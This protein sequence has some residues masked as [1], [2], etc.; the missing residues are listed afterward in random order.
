MHGFFFVDANT[1]SG[2]RGRWKRI[3]SFCGSWYNFF[4]RPLV[5]GRRMKSIRAREAPVTLVPRHGRLACPGQQWWRAPSNSNEPP[6]HLRLLPV[7]HFVGIARFLSIPTIHTHCTFSITKSGPS[8]ALAHVPSLFVMPKAQQ[9]HLHLWRKVLQTNTW[10]SDGQPTEWH[11]SHHLHG[12]VRTHAYLHNIPTLLLRPVCR[13]YWNFREQCGGS[14]TDVDWP[15]LETRNN[16]IRTRDTKWGQVLTHPWPDDKSQQRGPSWAETLLQA[17]KQRNHTQLFFPSTLDYKKSN[18]ECGTTSSWNLSDLRIRSNCGE[19]HQI[20]APEQWL[21]GYLD[22]SCTSTAEQKDPS[23]QRITFHPEDSLPVRRLQL[24]DTGNL[25]T[26][27]HSRSL[28]QPE[29]KNAAWPDET[30]DDNT[31]DLQKQHLPS[32]RNLLEVIR[33]LHGHLHPMQRSIHRHDCQTL[34]RSSTGALASNK[35]RIVIISSWRPLCE[36]TWRK[37]CKCDLL[38]PE[39]CPQSRCPQITHRGGHRHK[40]VLSRT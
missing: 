16:S 30:K 25:R 9:Q 1:V 13:W 39:A 34:T 11:L 3:A 36:K 27:Q 2:G 32:E 6:T 7:R 8:E 26:E 40:E 17:S 21:P 12:P 38:H 4:H 35:E 20:K 19:P 28:G 18:G 33:G 23:R 29:R 24:Q 37:A 10:P 22:Q 5:A 15:E 31:W 14:R